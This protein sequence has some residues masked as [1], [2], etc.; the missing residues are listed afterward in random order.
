MTDTEPALDPSAPV[1]ASPSPD[2]PPARARLR[3]GRVALQVALG[4][5]VGLGVAEGV[6]RHRDA[7]AFPLVNVYAPDSVRG[8]RLAPG[9]TTSVGRPGE[10]VTHVRVNHDGY[11]GADW[12]PPSPGEVLVVGDSLSFGLG[13]EEGEALP[14]RL[15]AA[16]PGGTTSV[17]DASVPTYGPPEYLATMRSVL[18]T[19]R[20]GTVVVAVNLI[21]D[22]A[23]LDRPNTSRHTA[24]D[25]W[26][27]LAGEG[28]PVRGSSPIVEWTIQRSHAAFSLW[29]WIRTREAA[30]MEREPEPGPEALVALAAKAAS[31]SRSIDEHRRDE[32]AR[33]AELLGAEV[34]LRAARRGVVDVVRKSR[35]LVAYAGGSEMEWDRYVRHE[36]E[37]KDEVFQV[38]YGGCSPSAGYSAVRFAG[39]KIRED[40]EVQLRDLA[41][42]LQPPRRREVEDA[43]ARRAAAEAR[44]AAAPTAPLPPPPPAA[45]LPIAPFFAE[46]QALAA[47]HG[48]RLAVVVIPLDAQV[49]DEARQR[50]SLAPAEARLLDEL[51][52]ALAAAAR[53]AGAVGVDAAPA[54]AAAGGG[55]F[56]PDGH[57]APAGHDAVAKAVAAA[58]S[59]S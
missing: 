35:G 32:A 7:G 6:F 8:V 45:P 27:A 41:R 38:W 1:D 54:L 16:L 28:A 37:P 48:A 19:R 56:L 43:F 26:A 3:I 52:A 17:I 33:I 4:L 39:P 36:G 24:V 22:L 49:S 50:R 53:S 42:G 57:L 20:S 46:A 34:E 11:R 21:N 10:R 23:E 31:S 25:G 13:V 29:R 47:E 40:V 55:A 14:A 2:V 51:S 15:R 9:S 59:S 58:L 18:A 44:F 5:A 12:P 30:S